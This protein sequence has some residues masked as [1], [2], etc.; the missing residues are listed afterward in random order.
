MKSIFS[1]IVGAFF[2]AVFG[3]SA[4][5]ACD[6][7]TP[8]PVDGGD[9]LI[10]V[11]EGADGPLPAVMFIHGYGSSAAGVLR[12]S[13]LTS[14][15]LDRGYA[16]IAPNGLQRQNGNGRSWSFH[17]ERPQRR[18]EIAFLLSVRDAAIASHNIRADRFLL[19]GFSIGGS[20]ASYLACQTPSGFAAYAPVG[21]SFWRPH[22]AECEGPVRLF[23]THG[24]KDEVV[25]L[26]GRAVGGGMANDPDAF[27]Q[28]DVFHAMDIWRQANGCVHMKADSFAGTNG[29]WLRKW[30]RCTPGSALEFALHPGGHSI[31]EGWVEMTIDWFEAL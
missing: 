26:E 15:F 4:A 7:T 14:V 30:E 24:W 23:H 12:N 28:G 16:V 25:P 18:D 1:L 13:A 6:A 20:M 27:V 2:G 8:C 10:A 3:A 31:P 19:S 11:P 29:Y 5:T 9:Y 17:P 21:G 22:P